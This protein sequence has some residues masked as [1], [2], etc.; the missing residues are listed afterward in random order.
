M[1]ATTSKT[2]TVSAV[3]SLGK[4]VQMDNS[5]V[6]T[7]SNAA[8]VN[9]PGH[10]ACQTPVLAVV[11]SPKLPGDTGGLITAGDTAT[12]TMVVTNNGPGT[13]KAVAISD[14][15]PAGNGVTWTTPVTTPQL[16][17]VSGNAGAQTLSCALG[18]MAATT[19]KTVTVSAVTS[20]TACTTMNNTANVTSTNTAP[21][22][23][24]G[25]IICTVPC[26]LTL[27]KTC[28]VVPVTAYSC[29]NNTIT[30]LTMSWG[31]SGNIYVKSTAG[32]V[33]TCSSQIMPGGVLTVTGYNATT[34]K[35]NGAVWDL[36][37]DAGCTTQVGES[38]FSLNCTDP[39][40]SSAD[41]CFLPQGDN[42]ATTCTVGGVSGRPCNDNWILEKI[43]G[44][45][46]TLDCN[47]LIDNHGQPESGCVVPPAGGQVNYQYTVH[48]NTSVPTV[49]T[50]TDDKISGMTLGPVTISPNN[51]VVLA[52]SDTGQ[53]GPQTVIPVKFNTGTAHGNTQGGV[54]QCSATDAAVVVPSCLLGDPQTG[55]L[56]PYSSG[57]RV[58]PFTNTAF[59]ESTVLKTNEPIVAFAG[60]TL[61]VWYSDEHA[62]S[63]GIRSTTGS[64]VSGPFTVT[65]FDT[66]GAPTGTLALSAG[67]DASETSV[68]RYCA[69]YDVN[70]NCVGSGGTPFGTLQVGA[71]T[72]PTGCD[73]QSRPIPPVVFITDITTTNTN[74]GDW[75]IAGG[76]GQP[77]QFVSGVWKGG[78]SVCSGTPVTCA[79]AFD[80]D[81]NT[82][83]VTHPAAP[84][85]WLP[86]PSAEPPVGGYNSLAGLKLEAYGTEVRWNVND[87]LF[88][89]LPLQNGHVYRVQFLVHDGDHTGDPGES[90]ATVA[91]PFSP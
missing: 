76:F 75:Q 29:T 62:L 40:M 69:S 20:P 1:A 35:T 22:S 26:D 28:S 83:N 12:F 45:A 50:V 14:T 90:C 8:S 58:G 91:M 53:P 3:T 30:A 18:D 87:L 51:T 17:T 88:N 43:T 63:L 39:G 11:K 77:A 52:T 86:G 25:R 5:A 60:G 31:G 48:N 37:S 74:S 4:C 23:D 34:D 24:T 79:P 71:L 9:D 56:Y 2:V 81:A 73:P 10:I 13:A 80:A 59:S 85:V 6:V 21:Q 70:H 27:E 57:G 78:V 42:N 65:A 54:D 19:S 61:R 16:C 66:T 49:V 41:D 36:Y 33:T 15:L 84:V 64:I 7:A 38:K 67:V 68:P 32:G 47:D 72:C 82:G 46:L 44:S 55:K 89:G